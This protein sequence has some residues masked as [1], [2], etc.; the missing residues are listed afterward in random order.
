M[1]VGHVNALFSVFERCLCVQM[2]GV[3]MHGK[4]YLLGNVCIFFAEHCECLFLCRE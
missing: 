2:P 4:V 1:T 3:N